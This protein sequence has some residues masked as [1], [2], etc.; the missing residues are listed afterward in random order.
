MN[1]IEEH[2]FSPF[3]PEHASVL[4]IGS[5]P[6]KEQT[7]EAYGQG[8]F[9]G[10]KR[11]QFWKI[12]RTVYDVELENT[13]DKQ[14]LFTTHGI[15]ITDIFLKIRRKENTNLDQNLE[16]IEYNDKAIQVILQQRAF[17]CILFTSKFVEN[18]F[19]KIFPHIKNTAV[20][21]SPSP[22]FARM[23]MAEKIAVY[24]KLLP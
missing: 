24:K 20:L 22:R 2:P 10:A 1:P 23:T 3:I 11:N 7:Q 9:Y 12:L 16:I 5:F 21:P 4:I 15:A 17:K 6:G 18:H 14:H 8:W 13:E 19:L